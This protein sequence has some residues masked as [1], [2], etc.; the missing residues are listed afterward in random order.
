M[1]GIA[2]GLSFADGRAREGDGV[3][4]L[5]YPNGMPLSS[6][7]GHVVGLNRSVTIAE[8]PLT[9]LL[10]Y[11][12]SV[13]PGNS[14]GPVV[15]EDGKV[16]GMT[17]AGIKG[18]DAQN[19]AVTG[20]APQITAWVAQPLVRS[21]TSCSVES[22]IEIRSQHAEASGIARAIDDWLSGGNK[23]FV[24]LSGA[25][26]ARVGTEVA[27]EQSMA[28]V[29]RTNAVLLPSVEWKTETVDVAEVT[30]QESTYAACL[31]KDERLTLSTSMGYWT[32]SDVATV[33]SKPC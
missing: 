13:M 23:G 16:V 10:Q 17:D 2:Q 22:S 12:A 21:L 31:I 28:D 8:Q 7:Q 25:E 32:I 33:S 26:L 3:I 11:D 1:P 30:Y 6:F 4:A 20:F 9:G 18:T 29:E 14:G 24:R 27:Y 5:G 19:L 15:T